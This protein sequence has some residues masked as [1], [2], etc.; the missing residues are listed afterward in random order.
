[1]MRLRTNVKK[2]RGQTLKTMR[3]YSPSLALRHPGAETIAA[4][5]P[6]FM[7]GKGT[8]FLGKA[9]LINET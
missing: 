6:E 7:R 2:V 1:M 3:L 8:V 4:M 9:I 5:T